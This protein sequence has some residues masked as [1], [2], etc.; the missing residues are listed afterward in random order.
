VVQSLDLGAISASHVTHHVSNQPPAFDANLF[1]N[2]IALKE[3]AKRT[4]ANSAN[5]KWRG[6]GAEAGAGLNITAA[7]QK[8]DATNLRWGATNP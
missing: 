1:D 5:E 2:D 3:S 6:L 4:A 7:H 8:A